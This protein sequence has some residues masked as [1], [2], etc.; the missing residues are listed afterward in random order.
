MRSIL[1]AI[2][3]LAVTGCV[4]L[5]PS[6]LSGKNKTALLAGEKGA[7]LTD[8]SSGGMGCQTSAMRFRNL[9]TNKVVTATAH[10]YGSFVVAEG[11]GMVAVPPG[12]YQL[13]G[14]TCGIPNYTTNGLVNIG[15]W[16][17]DFEVKPGEL[18]YVG[19]IRGETVPVQ[20]EEDPSFQDAVATA[21]FTLGISMFTDNSKQS[22]NFPAYRIMDLSQAMKS[23]L[24]EEHPDLVGS[25]VTGL[26]APLFTPN[27]MRLAMQVMYAKNEDG[28][29][30]TK[31]QVDERRGPAMRKGLE[32]SLL[33]TLSS[34]P[35]SAEKIEAYIDRVVSKDD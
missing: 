35:K 26:P 28:T 4:S 17:T 8:I 9:E 21:V 29:L 23:Y 14:G 30:P 6:Q 5:P 19:T 25:F 33:E 15:A 10:S 7:I 18:T 11:P 1:I 3:G 32:Y 24:T 31:E 16:F 2:M 13:V 34:D 22:G 27:G 20:W 12:R